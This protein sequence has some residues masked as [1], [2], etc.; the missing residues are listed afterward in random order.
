MKRHLPLILLYILVCTATLAQTPGLGWVLQNKTGTSTSSNSGNGI[1]ADANGT[2][3]ACGAYGGTI[4][5]DPGTPVISS[6]AGTYSSDAYIQKISVSGSLLWAKVLKAGGS[7]T[8]NNASRIATDAS[9]NVYIA[10]IFTNTVNLAPAPA[11]RSATS[12]GSFDVYV[13]KL[14]P[15]G[16]FI[17]A[18]TFGNT[19]RDDV[20]DM[21]V[22]AEGGVYLTGPVNGTIDFD[23][24]AEE[25]SITGGSNDIYALKISSD[26]NFDWLFSV[27]NAGNGYTHSISLDNANHVIIGG[28]FD[29]TVDF[30]PSPTQ[31]A[32]KTGSSAGFILVLDK[33]TNAFAWVYVINGDYDVRVRGVTADSTGYIYASGIYD[34]KTDFNSS[35]GIS[36]L[37]PVSPYPD[38]FILKL[39]PD[40][41]FC[42]AKSIGGTGIEEYVNIVYDSYDQSINLAGEQR[43]V[44]DCDPG[45]AVVNTTLYGSGDIFLAKLD[46]SGVYKWCTSLGGTSNETLY[47]HSVYQSKIYATG[48]FQGTVDFD[49]SPTT[50]NNLSVFGGN[51]N[52]YIVNVYDNVVTSISTDE[53]FNAMSAYPNP[54]PGKVNIQTKEEM[55]NASIK[56]FNFCGEIVFQ[57]EH[58]N[59]T[60]FSIDLL[61]LKTGLYIL[62]LHQL[63]TVTKI[64]L[65]KAQ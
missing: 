51:N 25:H 40:G 8:S 33:N 10:G 23:P 47:D 21:V 28:R 52:A 16:N 27:V 55:N 53:S 43:N 15:N 18:Y 65:V 31:T 57:E 61:S 64:K 36:Y 5:L 30:D 1:H 20:V 4:D 29:G 50:T 24:S 38:I 13:T 37:E 56:L 34:R 2:V 6:S 39:N 26:G 48:Y 49:P 35:A 7:Y 41:I 32:T 14:D 17:W 59:G 44:I 22:D 45:P 42:W 60:L 62:E 9:G 19:E 58:L 11:S 3:Y 46:T 54:S 12:L 63:N